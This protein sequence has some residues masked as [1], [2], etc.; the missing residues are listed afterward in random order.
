MET[1]S[2]WSTLNNLPRS[3]CWWFYEEKKRRN[4][5]KTKETSFL[6]ARFWSYCL[7]HIEDIKRIFHEEITLFFWHIKLDSNVEGCLIVDKIEWYICWEKIKESGN[8]KFW[9]VFCVDNIFR[10]HSKDLIFMNF[11][12]FINNFRLFEHDETN[13]SR[14][15]ISM[16][17]NLSNRFKK[18]RKMNEINKSKNINMSQMSDVQCSKIK[19]QNCWCGS[20]QLRKLTWWLKI[21]SERNWFFF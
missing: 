6:R 10:F 3:S 16:F 17:Q 9:E 11:F 20:Q 12:S 15:T 18:T 5:S 2:A 7:Q 21:R 14:K 4:I 1:F 13:I 19:I 8:W